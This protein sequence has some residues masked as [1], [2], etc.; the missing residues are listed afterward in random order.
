MRGMI[1]WS[2]VTCLTTLNLYLVYLDTPQLFS[3]PK[4]ALNS[5]NVFILGVEGGW[6]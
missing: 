3:V 4:N 1:I 5:C 6:N 2:A